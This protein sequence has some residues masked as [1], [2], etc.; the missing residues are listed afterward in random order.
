MFQRIFK[1]LIAGH[2]PVVRHNMHQR[3][4]NS[5]NNKMDPV[6]RVGIIGVPFDRGQKVNTDF[7][8]G[9]KAIRDG[10]L[11]AK[12]RE[13]NGNV[14]TLKDNAFDFFSQSGYDLFIS[15]MI[16]NL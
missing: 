15:V 7:H 5:A 12:I 4:C 6:L 16:I 14:H 9:P 2:S 3:Y 1:R 13:F 10:G 8:E 11:V